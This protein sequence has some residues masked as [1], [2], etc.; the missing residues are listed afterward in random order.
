[1]LTEP[2]LDDIG[3]AARQDVN[4]AAGPGVDEHGRVDEAAPQ[5]EAG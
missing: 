4:A 1:M 3:G 2:V 5:R